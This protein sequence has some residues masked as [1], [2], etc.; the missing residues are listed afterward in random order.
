MRS[1]GSAFSRKVT[2]IQTCPSSCEEVLSSLGDRAN[3]SPSITSS[4]LRADSDV[5]VKG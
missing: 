5:R 2:T 3:G 1:A 4:H